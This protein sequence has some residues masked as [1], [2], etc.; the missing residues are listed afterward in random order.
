M[1]AIVQQITEDAWS[2][3]IYS[4]KYIHPS[5]RKKMEGPSIFQYDF[6]NLKI[7]LADHFRNMKNTEKT[8]PPQSND[9]VELKRKTMTYEIMVQLS[10]MLNILTNCN[11][12]N[13][14]KTK[15]KC[16]VQDL[17]VTQIFLNVN[18]EDSGLTLKL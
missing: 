17:L 11:F 15:K 5:V 3:K 14:R 10:I 8:T 12:H 7:S 9:M 2:T 1:K 16:S 4:K 6:V 13:R 18:N